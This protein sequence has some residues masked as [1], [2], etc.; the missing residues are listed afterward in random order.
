MRLKKLLFISYILFFSIVSLLV[1]KTFWTLSHTF[2]PDFSV[3]YQA[4]KNM[5][6]SASAYTGPTSFTLFAYPLV[7]AL[8]FIPFTYVPYQTAQTIFLILNFLALI[9]IS[10]IISFIVA[11]KHSLLA[12]LCIFSFS[13]LSFP[14][15]FTLGMGQVNL[16]AYTFLL[17][18]LCFYLLELNSVG[19]KLQARRVPP[20]VV[21]ALFFTIA[22][23]LK[24]I[25]SFMILFFILQKPISTWL[26]QWK[27]VFYSII[28]S[29]GF[30]SISM[31]MDHHAITD[32]V[33]YVQKVVPS[34]S[35]PVGKSI[36][37][38]QGVMSFVFR[39]IPNTYWRLAISYIG[40]LGIFGI[41]LFN[42]IKSKN[43]LYRFSL[44]LTA[45]P[46]LDTLSWQHH[47]VFLIF[48]FVYAFYSFYQ[49]KGWFSLGWTVLAYLLVSWNFA[50]PEL[51]TSFPQN[52]LLSNTF[53]G[54]LVLFIVYIGNRKV[55]PASA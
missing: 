53:Y 32:Y 46:L 22:C 13:Y 52:L 1:C 27:I 10:W 16:I 51:F 20:F 41:L 34:V 12:S 36:Y 49:K 29:I 55:L 35:R 39:E 40:M 31:I 24:P 11:R 17:L 14:T 45:L 30:L 2:T 5:L 37:Y 26:S 23:L 47:F 3:Y 50:Y 25:L 33:Y 7:T 42:L 18:S 9:G 38:N 19:I 6:F 21:V 8:F 44:L 54:A 4:A 15:K 43:T 28:F 48:P